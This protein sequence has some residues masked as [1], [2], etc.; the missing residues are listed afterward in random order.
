VQGGARGKARGVLGAYA[1]VPRER[2]NAADGPFSSACYS[3]ADVAGLL[4]LSPAQVRARARDGFLR[5]ARGPGNSYRFSFQDLVLLRAAMALTRARVPA[6]RIRR[7]LRALARSLPTG[8]QLSGVRILADG[9]RVVVRE[10]GRL[11]QPESG[12]L[13]LDL[14]VG[15]LAAR[16]A[17]IAR[18]H[19][20]A[21]RTTEEALS[22]QDWF[23]LALELE[24]VDPAEAQDAYRR[25][26]AL[27]PTH[28]DT[29]VNLG[30]LLQERGLAAEAA[31]HYRQALRLAPQHA[32]AAYNLGTALEDLGNA[33][34]AITA[35]R[36]ALA[37]DDC[38]PDAH[39]NL[40][41][42]Y[43]KTGQPQAALRHLRAYRGLVTSE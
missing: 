12:Q 36:R 35:Y 25:A 22:A 33:M 1:A 10:D 23:G 31:Q 32:T 40:S 18:R 34:D 2:A 5:P 28:A 37:L 4:G 41:G 6:G 19:V 3:T 7:A 21:V 17:P 38:L 24:A 20:R 29:H 15:Q 26:L 16:A 42:L 13:L 30:R 9:C 14:N 27:D 8:R 11:W 39:Y 43:E